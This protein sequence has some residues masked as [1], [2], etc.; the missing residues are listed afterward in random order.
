MLNLKGKCLMKKESKPSKLAWFF[1]LQ[2]KLNI[3][4]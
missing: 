1:Y 3:L 2:K 4:N